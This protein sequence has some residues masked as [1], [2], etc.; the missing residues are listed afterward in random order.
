MYNGHA[1]VTSLLNTNGEIANTYYYDAFGNISESTGEAEN[2]FYY[3]GYFY[4]KETGLYY[5]NSRMYNPSSARFLQEDTYEGEEGSPLSL[6]KYTYCYNMPMTYVDPTGN[7]AVGDIVLVTGRGNASSYGDGNASKTFNYTKMKIFR[8]KSGR[9]YPY[10]CSD[11]LN[12]TSINQ[13]S[14]WSKDYQLS[15]ISSSKTTPV[16]TKPQNPTNPTNSSNTTPPPI[17]LNGIRILDTVYV[18][19]VG[20]DNPDGKISLYNKLWPHTLMRVLN[21]I[22]SKKYPFACSP[23]F[24][25]YSIDDW[26][27]QDQVSKNNS[28]I[29]N[30][31]PNNYNPSRYGAVIYRGSIYNIYVPDINKQLSGKIDSDKSWNTIE[32]FERGVTKF[33]WPKFIADFQADDFQ[34]KEISRD[35]GMALG[36]TKGNPLGL[37]TGGLT[38]WSSSMETTS[39]KFKY[40]SSGENKRVTLIVQDD[41]SLKTINS[42]V[43]KYK[44]NLADSFDGWI[45]AEYYHDVKKAY[46]KL[47]GEKADRWQNYTIVTRLGKGHKNNPAV[48]YLWVNSEKSLC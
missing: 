46:E 19:G 8:I 12:V 9:A 20:A 28:T 37:I 1:D 17:Q 13:V 40:E 24:N 36:G 3:S 42:L 38:A 34:G 22:P 43:Q 48:G 5:L 11:N 35:V 26:F 14:A 18:Q 45:L 7:Y 31:V 15:Y 33:N 2:N 29:N 6:N 16:T 32:S 41:S 4:D 21:I 30:G 23:D 44:T 47:S 39:I 25:S 27:R 10:A